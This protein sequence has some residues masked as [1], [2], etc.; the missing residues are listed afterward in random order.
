MY[1][2]SERKCSIAIA[3]FLKLKKN[4]LNILP[5]SSVKKWT[6]N[7]QVTLEPV[8]VQK[9]FCSIQGVKKMKT[10]K[11]STLTEG[12]IWITEA[13]QQRWRSAVAINRSFGVYL[14]WDLGVLVV[15]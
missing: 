1:V 9:N 6:N 12:R 15:H 2:R 14:I 7:E 13:T 5:E 4:Q 3:F 8:R 10:D 11:W